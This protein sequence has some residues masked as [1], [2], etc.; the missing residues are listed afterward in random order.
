ML[1]EYLPLS[2][3]VLYY[4]VS[5]HSLTRN[6]PLPKSIFLNTQA[7][8]MIVVGEGEPLS[9]SPC[10]NMALGFREVMNFSFFFLKD[11]G[12]GV[13]YLFR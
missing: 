2:C 7:P 9:S 6:S 5:S 10:R 4:T 3:P 1:K 8:S 11:I 13:I 12:I